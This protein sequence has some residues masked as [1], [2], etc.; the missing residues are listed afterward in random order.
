MRI[1]SGIYKG[2]TIKAPQGRDT[3]P[4]TDRVRESIISSIISW[5]GSLEGANVL[6]LFAGSGALGIECLSRGARSCT[7]CDKTKSA[8]SIIRENIESLKLGRSQ[9]RVLCIDAL[10]AGAPSSDPPFD[11]VLLDPPYR[12]DPSDIIAL[13]SDA[14]D[15]GKVSEDA[16]I[17]YEY[18]S[19]SISGSDSAIAA[20]G[21][22]VLSHKVYGSTCVDIIEAEH[23]NGGDQR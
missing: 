4:T 7:F 8:L 5:H 17:V 20:F 6:D 18:G 11:I 16:I 1:V 14:I 9:A 13:I 19:S 12:I 15:S 23:R 10:K 21:F 3:R 22:K 2:R